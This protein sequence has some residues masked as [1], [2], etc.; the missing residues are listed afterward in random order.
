MLEAV[1]EDWLEF[2]IVSSLGAL[3]SL[4]LPRVLAL[5]V[6]EQLGDVE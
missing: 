3:P 5:L 1:R 4:S 2:G 6:V